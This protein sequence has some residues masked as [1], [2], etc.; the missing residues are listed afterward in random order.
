[1]KYY[2][3]KKKK[4]IKIGPFI[5]KGLREF[6]KFYMNATKRFL[7]SLKKKIKNVVKKYVPEKYSGV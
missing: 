7:M 3:R 5:F 6:S 2:K 4:E 1:M